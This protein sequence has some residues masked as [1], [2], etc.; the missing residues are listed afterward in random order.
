LTD[1]TIMLNGMPYPIQSA[2]PG[3]PIILLHGFAGS[4]ASWEPIDSALSERYHV[5]SITLPGHAAEITA[6]AQDRYSIESVSADLR[7]LTDWLGQPATLVGYSMGGRLALHTALRF[8]DRVARLVLES[9]S[10]GLESFTERMERL[11]SDAELAA[12]I[13]ARGIDWFVSH[14][15]SLPLFASHQRMAPEIRARLRQ[16]RTGHT[17]GGLAS[18]LRG[19]GTGTQPSHW[20][21]LATL[22]CP[23]LL[24]AGD[25]DAKYREIARKMSHLMPNASLCIVPDSGHTVHLEQ[26]AA[27]LS[28]V[29]DFLER[30]DRERSSQSM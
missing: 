9:A 12:S 25:E 21:A 18:S 27:F 2:G 16:I 28:A 19:M 7:A 20:D 17:P 14:W 10:P 4:L 22:P 29:R 13:E 15:E 1:S 8:P 30:T 23:T 3:P 6:I 11:E 26:P 24:I 5:V